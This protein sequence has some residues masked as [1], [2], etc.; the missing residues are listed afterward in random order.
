MSTIKNT[1]Y[2]NSYIVYCNKCG[3]KMHELNELNKAKSS[4]IKFICYSCLG[5]KDI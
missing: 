4:A 2:T 3:N 5:K 1:D